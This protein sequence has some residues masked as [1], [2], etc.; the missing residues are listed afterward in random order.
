MF[1]FLKNLPP[2]EKR[3]TL[4]TVLTLIRIGL[5]PF[6]VS[7]MIIGLWGWACGLFIAAA[8]TDIADGYLARWLNERTFLGACLDPIAD[9]LLVVSCFFTLAFVHTPLFGIPLWFVLL[10]LLKEII[11]IVGACIIYISKG[12]VE[13]RPTLL[14]KVTTVIQMSFIVWLFACYFF[15]W[16]PIKT[17]YIMLG[18]MLAALSI[19]LVQYM[20][21]GLKQVRQ[22]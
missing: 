5:V 9:K 2:H 20:A 6:V 10:V 17:Y 22:Q 21:I 14:G 18:V 4:S 8:L 15:R 16:T 19:S 11:L 7:S 13:I 12:S 3:L 1:K